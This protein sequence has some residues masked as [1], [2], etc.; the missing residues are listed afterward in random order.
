MPTVLTR[1]VLRRW[2]TPFLGALLFYGFLLLSWEMVRISKEI[3]SEGAP[4]RW[5]VPLLLTSM[6][7]N[8]GL[9][10]PMAAV[11]GGLL[12]TQQLMEGSEL[13][14]AQGLGAG[15]R[16][17]T[18]PWY[19]MALLLV[20]VASLNAHFTVPFAARMQQRVRTHMA[21]EAKARFLRPGAPPWFPPSAPNRAFWVSP[22]GQ[23]HIMESTALGVQHLTASS[24]TYA[25]EARPDG[26]SELQL[27][28]AGLQGVLYQ[29]S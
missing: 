16:T 1:Y 18:A 27:H 22:G 8:L 5:L 11:L 29:T 6:P 21:E 17:W 10:L 23:I 3:F 7:E 26:S 20:V 2:A 12:G 14:A 15:R 4:L 9:V 19:L 28:L 24:M 13:V 25:L